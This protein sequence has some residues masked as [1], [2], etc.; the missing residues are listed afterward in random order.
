MLSNSHLDI[1][2]SNPKKMMT[3]GRIHKTIL[4]PGMSRLEGLLT[5]QRPKSLVH[6]LDRTQKLCK[7]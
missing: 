4:K 6:I 2:T 7:T 5:K 3:I 1:R